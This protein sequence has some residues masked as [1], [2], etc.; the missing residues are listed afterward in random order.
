M[1]MELGMEREIEDFFK[2]P[3]GKQKMAEIKIVVT[4]AHHIRVDS[5]DQGG[6]L[7]AGWIAEWKPQ[8]LELEGLHVGLLFFEEKKLKL[9]PLLQEILPQER[10]LS[11]PPFE[12]LFDKPTSLLQCLKIIK[13]EWLEKYLETHFQEEW[14]SERCII[15]LC[16]SFSELRLNLFLD[17]DF[18]YEDSP[19]PRTD[20][21]A[22]TLWRRIGYLYGLRRR[23][24]GIVP[25]LPMSC[26]LP[27]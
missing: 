22:E 10:M 9:I 26:F 17:L 21:I 23:N 12:D 7:T 1:E 8:L 3:E 18:Y 13:R 4:L 5:V 2:S 15:G 6:K 24:D 20:E 25:V 16:V 27:P 14:P 11:L 19:L